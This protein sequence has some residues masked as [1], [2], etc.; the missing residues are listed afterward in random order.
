MGRQV[1]AIQRRQREADVYGEDDV[2][3]ELLDLDINTSYFMQSKI[4]ISA[5]L[6]QVRFQLA[7]GNAEYLDRTL[8]ALLVLV[9]FAFSLLSCISPFCDG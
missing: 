8:H 7:D 9:G 2:I 4:S 3:E 6:P 5:N 1:V